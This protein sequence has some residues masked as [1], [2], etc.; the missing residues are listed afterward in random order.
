MSKNYKKRNADTIINTKS[1]KCKQNFIWND[2][3]LTNEEI[4]EQK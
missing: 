1:K 2:I 3:N 4:I